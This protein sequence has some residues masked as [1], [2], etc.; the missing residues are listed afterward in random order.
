M[1][2]LIEENR[3][4][5]HH[6]IV[7]EK[8][9]LKFLKVLDAISQ[10]SKR[11]VLLMDMEIGNCGWKDR[12]NCWYVFFDLANKHWRSLITILDKLEY[13]LVLGKD[14]NLYLAKRV[15]S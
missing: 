5:R 2:N 4:M 1:I 7:E 15:E 11:G 6:V 12:P 14:A 8:E 10:E 3:K 9:L 13:G